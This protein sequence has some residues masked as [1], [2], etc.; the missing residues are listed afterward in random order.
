MCQRA[1]TD[2][3]ASAMGAQIVL[4]TLGTVLFL[5]LSEAVHC[6]PNLSIKVIFIEEKD[7]QLKA[8]RLHS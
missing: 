6:G 3:R 1:G 5:L 4:V 7:V 2:N 8:V